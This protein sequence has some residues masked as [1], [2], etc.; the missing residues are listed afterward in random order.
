MKKILQR[1]NMLLGAMIVSLLGSAAPSQC[2]PKPVNDEPTPKK[3]GPPS[4]FVRPTKPEQPIP[5]ERTDSI[6]EDSIPRP[7]PMPQ[8]PVPPEDEG[9]EPCVYGSPL[10]DNW[11]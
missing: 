9:P 3:Y 4:E 6:P 1:I 7:V 2:Q 11:K 5:S 10:M 8:N